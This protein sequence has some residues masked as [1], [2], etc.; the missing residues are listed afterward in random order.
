MG[1]QN[2][3]PWHISEDLKNFKR[4]TTGNTIIMGR[5]TFDSIGKPLPNRN[6]LV[7]SGSMEQKEGIEVCKSIPEALEK[8]KKHGKEIFI[9]GGATIYQQALPFVERMYIS[10]IK[11]EYEGDTYF[12]E[13]NLK[14]WYIISEE[15]HVEFFLVTYQRKE[16]GIPHV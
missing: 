10:W 6:N 13:V 5:K 3:L 12:P 1:K 8:A 7:I 4:L 11:E 15:E 2:A 16:G 14:E 9:I